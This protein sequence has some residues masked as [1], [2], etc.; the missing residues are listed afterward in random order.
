MIKQF[1]QRPWVSFVMRT[2]IYFFIILALIYLY[3]YSGVS[4]GNFIY[5]EF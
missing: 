4:G 5:K 1:F 2:I 3:S